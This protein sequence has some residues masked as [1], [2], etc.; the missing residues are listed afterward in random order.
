VAL[1][2]PAALPAVGSLVRT[3][4]RDWVVL[5]S[6]HADVVWLRQLTGSDEDASGVFWPLEREA[7]HSSS[8]APP[9]PSVA[10]DSIGCILLQ[11]AARVSIWNGAAPFRS[12]RRLPHS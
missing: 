3:R 11:D 7:V 1:A 4:G 6:D 8:F 2:T 12:P 5:S 10:G 9:D